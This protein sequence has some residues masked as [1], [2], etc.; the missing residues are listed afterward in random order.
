MVGVALGRSHCTCY[1]DA[2]D[3]FLASDDMVN[4]VPVSRPWMLP[5][6]FKHSQLL[7][8]CAC[9]DELVGCTSRQQA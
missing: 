3:L 9:N 5:G 2:T 1:G 7:K 4:R 6:G 8:D